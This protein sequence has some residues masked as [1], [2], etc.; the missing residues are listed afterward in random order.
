MTGVS[1]ALVMDLYLKVR[2]HLHMPGY[3]CT[4]YAVH[5]QCVHSFICMLH[6]IV[7]DS[8]AVLVTDL[9]E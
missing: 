3:F 5:T 6:L 8:F 1:N 7:G 4:L 9:Q 2:T